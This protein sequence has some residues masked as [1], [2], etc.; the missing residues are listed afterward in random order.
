MGAW[1]AGDSHD[2]VITGWAG[3]S[4]LKL[5]LFANGDTYKF[6]APTL[7]FRESRIQGSLFA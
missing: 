2:I 6:A 7:P 5:T 3:Y 4:E 1:D